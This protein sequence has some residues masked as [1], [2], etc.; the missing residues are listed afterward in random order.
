MKIVIVDDSS[1]IR[2][3]IE[4]ILNSM[5]YE[6][7]HAGNGQEALDLLEKYAAEVEMMILD[8]NMPVLDGWETLAALRKNKNYD[9]ICVLMV[10]TE[11]ENE[12]INQ[13]FAGGAQGY[14]TK[15]FSPEELTDKIKTTLEKFRSE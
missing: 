14:L 8:W 12:K 5:G 11:S 10:S 1:V 15:P 9:P 4:R 3:I 13:A 2:S 6:S 7:L